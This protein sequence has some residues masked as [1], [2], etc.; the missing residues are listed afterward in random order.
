MEGEY[1]S[2][3]VTSELSHVLLE[4]IRDDFERHERGELSDSTPLLAAGEGDVF[5][6][7]R[8]SLAEDKKKRKFTN[9]Q[10]YFMACFIILNFAN[11]LCYSLIAPFFPNEVSVRSETGFLEISSLFQV[12]KK[13]GNATISGLIFASYEFVMLIMGPVFGKY[14]SFLSN[15]R[16]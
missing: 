3:S 7:R 10:K 5:E 11:F 1:T 8:K 14:V 15:F 9:R 6:A 2:R 4:E 13:G 12:I 16:L